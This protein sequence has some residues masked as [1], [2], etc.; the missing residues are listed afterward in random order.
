MWTKEFSNFYLPADH[1]GIVY[2]RIAYPSVEHFFVAMKSVDVAERYKIALIAHPAEAKKYGRSIQL[3]PDW[4]DIRVDVLRYGI[5]QKFLLDNDLRILLVDSYPAPIT[6]LVHWHDNFWASCICNG[7]SSKEK[8][9]MLGQ[10]LMELR[11][12]LVKRA[13]DPD[14][15]FLQIMLNRNR[16]PN[17]VYYG[18]PCKA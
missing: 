4:L 5:R 17:A 16:K 13:F 18:T 11:E 8:V 15:H 1:L 12:Q 3:R 2:E 9:N 10:L 14:W 6:H 7:C